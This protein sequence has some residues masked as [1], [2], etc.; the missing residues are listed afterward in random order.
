M[1][2]IYIIYVSILQ[3]GYHRG[4]QLFRETEMRNGGRILMA[5]LNLS[6]R[7]AIRVATFD[8]DHSA[9]DSTQT[10]RRCLILQSSQ[11]VCQSV[12]QSAQFAI[13]SRCVR[14]IDQSEVSRSVFTRDVQ[15]Y[16]QVL[17]FNF[18]FDLMR[19]GRGRG[20]SSVSSV[21]FVGFS[22]LKYV[23]K[24]EFQLVP[25]LEECT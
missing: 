16:R 15:N 12:S 5:A 6:V 20:G 8:A 10:I 11:S 9:T 23:Q 19:A 1:V 3:T 24:C 25:C 22:E 4:R 21:A 18:T 7:T 2:G 14:R 17:V 13:D